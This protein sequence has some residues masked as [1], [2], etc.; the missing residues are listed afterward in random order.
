MQALKPVWM[1]S[2]ASAAQYVRPGSLDFDLLV[3]DEASQM[4]PEYALSAILRGKQFVVVGDANQLPPSDHFQ[5]AATTDEVDD[6]S[7]VEAGT[8]SILDLAN[9]RLRRKRRLRC[10]YRFQH[11]RLI[12][13]SNRQFYE[14]DLVVFPSPRGNDDDLLG[15]HYVHVPSIQP[16]TVYES[17]INQREAEAV[18]AEAYRIMIAHPENSLG[19][20]A[21]NAKQTELIQNEFERLGLERPEVRNYIERFAGTVDEF[22]I[23][24]L[25]NVQGDKTRHHSDLDG[26]RPRQ[27]WPGKAALRADESRGRLAPPQRARHPGQAFHAGLQFA[28]TR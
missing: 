26:L 28:P 22:F 25:E 10:A 2:P 24:N 9:Q 1:M 17:S 20:A 7:G 13:F 15:V 3:I 5:L 11:E 27:R 23:K 6:D 4:R 19:I 12:N 18:I 21:M 16:D 8:E 14:N